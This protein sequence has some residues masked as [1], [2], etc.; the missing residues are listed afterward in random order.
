VS[1]RAELLDDAGAA[2][3]SEE[4][5]RSR[6]FLDAEGVT[7][8]LRVMADDATIAAPVIVRDIPGSDLRDAI[9]PYGYPGA[10]VEGDA[11]LDSGEVD[12][13]ATR[14]VSAFLRDRV[15]GEP[16]LAGATERSMLQVADPTRERKSRMS[17]RQQI[18]RNERDGYSIERLAGPDAGPGERAA[19]AAAYD[20]TMARA[21]AAERYL[22]G[23]EYWDRLL[24]SPYAWLFLIR[25][26]DGEIAGGAIAVLSD[27]VVHY[28]L[29]GTADDHLSASPAK[30]LIAVVI[31]F[32][33]ELDAPMNLGGG[34]EPGDSLEAFKRGFANAELPFR[35]HEI[36]CDPAAYSELAA[37]RE[38]SGFFPLYRAP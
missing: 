6:A 28:Y 7:H 24:S 13:S 8:T 4:F 14:L 23:P 1:A 11:R 25:A 35:T 20:Q 38:D 27:G 12:W 31:D 37:D 18:R 2:A 26:P 3:E 34:V 9:S 29:S 19:Y 36:V 22:Y 15:G 16:C 30:N 17:D 33:T 5:F 21:N 32:A 10:T